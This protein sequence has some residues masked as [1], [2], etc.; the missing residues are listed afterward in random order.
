[1]NF[2]RLNGAGLLMATCVALSVGLTACNGGDDGGAVPPVV[3][4]P[5]ARETTFGRIEGVDDTAKSGTYAWKGVP[6]AKAPVGALDLDEGRATRQPEG[7]VRIGVEGHG[8]LA[9]SR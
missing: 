1:M 5:T 9:R 6:F 3:V 8:R 7:A 2:N 4:S